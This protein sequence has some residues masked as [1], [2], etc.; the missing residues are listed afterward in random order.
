MPH[1]RILAILE[2][3]Q[4]AIY[5]KAGYANHHSPSTRLKLVSGK[6]FQ[7]IGNIPYKKETSKKT[8]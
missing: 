5:P 4:L 1:T 2:K 6:R 3:L 7:Y 8:D